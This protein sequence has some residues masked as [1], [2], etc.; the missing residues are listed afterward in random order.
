M[1]VIKSTDRNSEGDEYGSIE[2]PLCSGNVEKWINV[3]KIGNICVHCAKNMIRFIFE[4]LTGYYNGKQ[5]SLLDIMGYG[6]KNYVFSK[7]DGVIF[8][9]VENFLEL[10]PE[11]EDL[12]H[13]YLRDRCDI[14]KK[15]PKPDN[16]R[17]EY[18][19]CTICGTHTKEWIEVYPE[20]SV[21]PGKNLC[22]GCASNTMKRMFLDIIEYHNG[23][24][25]NLDEIFYNWLEPHKVTSEIEKEEQ[26]L[27][28]RSKTSDLFDF[29]D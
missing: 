1:S 16:D 12:Y 27:K 14:S 2:C 29:D 13:I 20:T 22:I 11:M 4:T 17:N 19:H 15:P 10:E 23:V 28:N 26:R 21:Y 6:D 24:R 7:M 9:M 5:I 8:L 3:Y 18:V 25:V